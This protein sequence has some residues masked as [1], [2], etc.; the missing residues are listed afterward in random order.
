[1]ELQYRQ[2]EFYY[3]IFW[4]ISKLFPT[5]ASF[6]CLSNSQHGLVWNKSHQTS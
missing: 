2:S 6:G 1:M 4:E 3:S 5:K